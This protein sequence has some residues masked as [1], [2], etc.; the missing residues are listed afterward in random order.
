MAKVLALGTVGK[1]AFCTADTRCVFLSP[2]LSLFAAIFSFVV[3]SG[4]GRK[5]AW[6]PIG[7]VVLK[8]ARVNSAGAV[9][10]CSAV[11]II[12]ALQ[13]PYFPSI[14]HHLS[15]KIN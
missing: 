4:L 2:S 13:L 3:G 1:K 6:G 11:A 10:R 14:S 15:F 12:N 5:D 8:N 7:A 9:S